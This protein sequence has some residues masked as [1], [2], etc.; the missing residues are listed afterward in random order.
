M[1]TATGPL[2][3][4]RIVDFT[5]ALAG[6]FCTMLLGDLGADVVKIE[7]PEKGDLTRV[8]PPFPRDRDACDVAEADSGAERRRQ[9]LEVA[10]LPR[11]VLLVVR[12]R[13]HVLL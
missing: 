5:R 7:D 2:A 10:H 9:G 6:P 13:P 3:G 11:V 12:E 8:M 1:S 4:I